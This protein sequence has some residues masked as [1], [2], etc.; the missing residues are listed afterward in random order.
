MWRATTARSR[1]G[2]VGSFYYRANPGVRRM[3]EALAARLDPSFHL[4][5]VLVPYARRLMLRQYSPLRLARQLGRA[6]IDA[7]RLGVDLPQQARRILA[8]IERGNFQ[9]GVRPEGFEPLVRRLERLANRIVLGI[10]TAAFVIGLAVL[11]SVYQLP[12]REQG[13]A[14]LFAIGF[15]AAS[16]LGA[17][18]AWSILRSGRG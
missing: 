12:G 17:Y 2:I 8:E 5:D 18:L 1:L 3:A 4:I 9:M 7:A 14:V 15:A 13:A 10:L 6:G 16:A 11:L